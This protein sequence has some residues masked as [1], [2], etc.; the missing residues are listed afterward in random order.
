VVRTH[1]GLSHIAQPTY[2]YKRVNCEVGNSFVGGRTMSQS[3]HTMWPIATDG[4]ACSVCLL[5]TFV[6]P[7]DG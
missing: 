1:V 2:K 3:V 6:S 7:P 5:V 4:V